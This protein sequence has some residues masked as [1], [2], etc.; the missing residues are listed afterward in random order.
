MN[1][2]MPGAYPMSEFLKDLKERYH[3]RTKHH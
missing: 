3:N 1:N 2:G